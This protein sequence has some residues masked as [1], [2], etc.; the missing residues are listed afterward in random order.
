MARKKTKTVKS[1]VEAKRVKDRARRREQYVNKSIVE[2]RLNAGQRALLKKCAGGV[3]VDDA[4][5]RKLRALRNRGLV[6][7]K[8]IAFASA[9]GL[10]LLR[11]KAR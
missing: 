11:K 5:G 7:G 2:K 3:N 6:V 1:Q 10:D 8:A 9:A 4:D